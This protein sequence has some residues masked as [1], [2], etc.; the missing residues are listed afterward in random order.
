MA[1]PRSKGKPVR[2]AAALIGFALLA[3]L[4]GLQGQNLKVLHTAGSQH[5]F[6]VLRN[7]AG[8]ILASGEL[9]QTPSGKWMKLRV[10]F[11]FRDGSIDDE[12]TIYSQRRTFRLISD[13]HV[14]SGPSY[15]NPIDM[16]V[17]ARGQ[18][19]SV[20]AE[21]DQVK[22]EHMDL[23]PDL[24]NGIL[25]ILLENVEANGPK[26]E[27]PYLAES[28]KPRMVKLAIV[29]QGEEPFDVSGR[30]YK[31]MKYDIKVEL[32][33]LTGVLA[34]MIGKQPPDFHVWVTESSVPAII[35]I[36]GA[37]YTEGPIWS[38]QLASPVW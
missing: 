18:Q 16:T 13:H 35:R 9:T 15:P 30:A 26:I 3:P 11:H 19:V 27:V 5:G 6:L 33:G 20:G 2:I 1:P 10:V 14:Q 38:V 24:A 12:T 22:T 23:P 34:P 28:T 21:K 37:F 7:L 36:D 31:A 32:G 25:F 17:D 4:R 29:Q 8:E